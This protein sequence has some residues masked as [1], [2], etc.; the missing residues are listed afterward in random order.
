MKLRIQDDSVRFRITIKELEQLTETGVVS[1]HTCIPMKIGETQSVFR[2]E[3][4]AA[5]AGEQSDLLVT[6]FAFT[7]YLNRTDLSEL[8]SET[9]EGV[10]IRREWA[11]VAGTPHRFIV[12]VEKDRPGSACEKPEQW[13]YDTVPGSAPTTRPIPDG[14]KGDRP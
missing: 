11:D 6:P 4:R 10:Y 2:Y 7:L 9:K 14:A 1:C 5:H 12:F 3:L 13:I 8:V